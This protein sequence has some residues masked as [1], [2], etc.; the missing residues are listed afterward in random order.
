MVEIG[1]QEVVGIGDAK[2]RGTVG[3]GARRNQAVEED[4]GE[5]WNKADQWKKGM[6][7]LGGKDDGMKRWEEALRSR[8]GGR[9]ERK[10]REQL[11][12]KAE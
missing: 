11:E 1:G 6:R 9:D 8:E 3:D 10:E 5:G 12:K 2:N 4:Y 7:R